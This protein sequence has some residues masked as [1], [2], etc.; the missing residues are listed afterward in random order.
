MRRILPLLAGLAASSAVASTILP[1]KLDELAT[2]AESIVV[3]KVVEVTPRFNDARTLILSDVTVAVDETIAGA[4]TSYLT[5]SEYGGRVGDVELVAPGLPQYRPGDRVVVFVC[6]DALGFARTCG[7]TQGRL[8]VVEGDGGALRAV[9]STAD[10]IVDEPIAALKTKV[11]GLRA[12]G[13]R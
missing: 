6:R 1:V 11:R 5:V 3:G 9:G 13:A 7:A 8:R 4:S 2:R 12:G 10:G